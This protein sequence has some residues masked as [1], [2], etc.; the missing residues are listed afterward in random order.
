MEY[1]ALYRKYRPVN[2]REM[3]GQELTVEALR[4]QIR[5][6]RVG[7]AYLF[8][9]TR[10]TGKT[11]TAKILARAVNCLNPVDG[12]ACGTCESCRRMLGETSFD[13]LEYDAA[14]NS[15]V[16]DM[17]EIL[18]TVQYP[19]Q[20]G[21]NK[22]YIIDEVHMLSAGASNALLKTLEEPP[23]YMIF[24]LATTE[25]Q[26][27]LP[28]I[29]SRCQR[30]DFHRIPAA[31]I[32][33]RLA[34][35][36]AQEKAGGAECEATPEALARIARAAE[37]GMRDALSILDMCLGY[38]QR[39]D[40]DLVRRVLGAS[41][42]DFLFRFTDALLRQ[43]AAGVLSLIDQLM[44][45]GDEPGVFAGEVAQHL[46]ALL[47]AKYCGDA[48][49]DL[50]EITAEDAKAYLAQTAEA[51]E[52]RLMAMMGLFLDVDSKLRYAASPRAALEN[53]AL[54]ACIR[55][56]ETD[57]AALQ[58]RIEELERR[59]AALNEQLA[60]G[61]VPVPAA[62]ASAAAAKPA[63]AAVPAPPQREV[64]RDAQKAWRKAMEQLSKQHPGKFPLLAENGILDRVE[65]NAFIWKPKT[66]ESAFAASLFGREG[67]DA[68]G[69]YLTEITGRPSRL[70][71]EPWA[72]PARPVQGDDI[73]RELRNTFGASNVREID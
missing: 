40:E 53:A 31:Q 9:G 69:G 42:R 70:V 33:A 2:F 22:V 34:D 64:E 18:D 44:R 1:Q 54:H 29:R 43:D 38:G 35:V 68:M 61:A 12:D 27:V 30:Y 7:H 60:S 10:G 20:F 15:R 46:R 58:N 59:L 4:S 71:M 48:L 8:T 62:P 52:T 19:P 16:D 63:P 50:L 14:S 47:M 67:I 28:T 56:G 45:E 36:I 66:R 65:D 11:S 17:R 25:P 13:V 21:K 24:I 51:T 72:E 41:G 73:L 3:V 5:T 39:V 49:P 57:T 32:A 6:G 55:T 23:A 26:K 37:G